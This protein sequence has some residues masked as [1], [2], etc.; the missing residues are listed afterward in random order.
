MNRGPDAP[1][2][3]VPG[4][5]P[6]SPQHARHGDAKLRAHSHR[7][8]SRRGLVLLHESQPNAV[9]ISV[10]R[11]ELCIEDERGEDVSFQLLYPLPLLCPWVKGALFACPDPR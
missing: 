10:P 1:F 7:G 9:F 8:A 3:N 11:E 4:T 6:H 2:G 5:A